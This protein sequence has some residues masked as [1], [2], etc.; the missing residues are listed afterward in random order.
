MVR[1]KRRKRPTIKQKAEKLL[2][3]VKLREL[4]SSKK[5]RYIGRGI[6]GKDL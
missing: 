4:E 1:R 6:S 3:M 2:K 5:I